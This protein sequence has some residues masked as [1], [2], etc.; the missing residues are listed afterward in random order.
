MTD[1]PISTDRIWRWFAPIMSQGDCVDFVKMLREMLHTR[2]DPVFDDYLYSG[3]TIGKGANAPDL[4]ELRDGLFLN[5]FDGSGVTTEQGFFS[6]HILH[7]FVA[8]STPTFHVHWTHNAAAPSGDVKWL[9]DC[10]ISKGYSAGTYGAPTTASTIQTAGPQ[11]THH[12]TND[13]D[14]PLSTIDLEP[15]TVIIGRLYRDP[16]DGDD[17]FEDDAFLVD[18]DLHYERDKIGTIERNRPYSKSG[19]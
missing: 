14:M 4:A 19:Y 9:I 1:S 12:I 18:I 11:F 15:D 10:S 5:A 8:G 3:T 7:G 17:T 6:I 13:D 16:T 2:L